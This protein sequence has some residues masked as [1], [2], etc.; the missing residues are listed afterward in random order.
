MNLTDHL[1]KYGIQNFKDDSYWSWGAEIL[2][3][4][5]GTQINRLRKPLQR[6]NPAKNDLFRFYEYISNPEVAS[7]VHSMKADA[8]R[9]TAEFVA[10]N[11]AGSRVLDVGCGIGYLTT[12]WGIAKPDAQVLGIDFSIGSVE[13]AKA[14]A[15]KLSLANVTFQAIDANHFVPA[16]PY[17]CLVD[18]QGFITE[19]SSVKDVRRLLSWLTP[20]GQLICVPAI[21]TLS[22]FS[23][24]LDVLENADAV[25]LACGSVEFNDL[26]ELGAYPTMIIAQSKVASA[27]NRQHMLDTYQAM[28]DDLHVKRHHGFTV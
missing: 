14:Y 7:V 12:W 1:L 10:S 25:V 9:A 28:V 15:S 2:G 16:A 13:V 23:G 22:E 18:T 19:K 5:R 20:G 11:L 27:L 24:F 21:G 6:G 26:G 3:Q 8:I 4:R 17:D